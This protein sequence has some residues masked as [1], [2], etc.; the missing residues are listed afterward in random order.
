MLASLL[1]WP[2]CE[3]RPAFGA[4]CSVTS[5]QRQGLDRLFG[6]VCPQPRPPTPPPPPSVLLPQ[7]T[8]LTSDL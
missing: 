1:K 8:L 4:L 7:M 5:L 3:T 6:H 2:V